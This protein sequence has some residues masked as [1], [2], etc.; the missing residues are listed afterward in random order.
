[1]PN[2]PRGNSAPSVNKTHVYQ[3]SFANQAAFV[4]RRTP[5]EILESGAHHLLHGCRWLVEHQVG[6]MQLF[7]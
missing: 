4:R 3:Q 2:N 1:M 6:G 5:E 7:R